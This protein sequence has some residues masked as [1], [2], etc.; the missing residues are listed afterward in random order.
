MRPS[1]AG[2]EQNLRGKEVA[3]LKSVV[4]IDLGST[5][6][7][8]VELHGGW[9][10]Y[11]VVKAAERR[12]P[13]DHGTACP[14]ELLAQALT[15][16]L[17]A[18]AIKPAHVVSAIPAHLSFV[19]NLQL[20]FRDPRKIREVLKF[21]MEPHI[22]YPVEEA[23]VDFAKLRDTDGAGCEVMAVAVPKSTI[24]EHLR[25]FELAGLAPDVVDWEVFGELNGY[26]AW[27]PAEHP[28]PVALVNLGASKTTVKIVKDG[29]VRFARSIVRGGNALTE[30][31]RQRLTLTTAQAEAL[32]L[33]D[34]DRDRAS[35]A[36][37]IEAFL[38]MLAKEIDH[39]LLAYGTRAGEEQ[40]QEIVLLGG[41]A[42]LPEALPFFQDHYGLPTTLFDMEQRLFPAASMILQPQAGL[43]MPVAL[44][45]AVRQA[46]RQALGLDL[47]REEF[48][49]HKS[50]EE[51]RGQLL[52]IG[53]MVALLV[54]LSLFDLY[55]HL[56]TKEIHYARLQSQIQAQFRDTFPDVRRISNEMAQARERLRE[57]ETNLKG[58]GTL[59]GPQGS[60]LEMLRELA[61]R[62]PQG[63]PV[64]ITD[65]TISTE[66]IGIS[67]ET[68]S[69]DGV[70]GLKKAYAASAYFDEVKVSQARAGTGGKGVEFKLALTFKKL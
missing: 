70:D 21:E 48:T 52:S 18:H 37:S 55:Y 33:S 64:K 59:S 63:L 50:Y 4:G 65:L 26:L 12:L 69:F 46:K 56:H 57:L 8:V 15:E 29:V 13:T 9:R 16:L 54:G 7:K 40:V 42:A 30:S 3:M 44:G 11:E 34:R 19:R 45:L 20:P 47:R 1:G 27:R 41:G 53:G 22:P 28:G 25:V 49:L 23:I 35:I 58:V 5:S 31:I 14:P 60:S 67:G 36:E 32:K 24:D 38:G 61:V 17:S 39:T 2:G 66:G 10:G 62:T 51:V 6:L 68:Q 43:V